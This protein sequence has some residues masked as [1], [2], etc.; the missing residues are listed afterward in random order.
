MWISWLF[1]H[2]AGTVQETVM[3]RL[4]LLTALLCLLVAAG[5]RAG[6][7]TIRYWYHI[8]NPDNNYVPGLVAKFEA[9]NPDIKVQAELIPWSSYYDNLHTSIIGG[10]AP[11]CGEVKLMAMP[12]LL[13]MEALEPL[14]NYIAAWDGR[15]DILDELWDK[16]VAADGKTYLLPLQYIVSYL[17]IRQD[18][19]DK[20]NVKIPTN[21]DEFLE[22][23]KALTLDTDG[24]G[25]IDIYGYGFR[26]GK[27]GQEHWGVFCMP[28]ARDLTT[29]Q[30]MDPHTVENNQFV[31]DMFRK[32]KV[33]PPSAPND[34]FIEIITAF[35]KGLTAMTIQH[36]G[37]AVMIER[38]L[39]DKATAVMVPA[40]GKNGE[41]WTNFGDEE[42]AIF[43]QSKNKDA[44][45]KWI[46]FLATGEYNRIWC[47]G[48]S[49]L[50]V[51]KSASRT[52][53]AHKQRFLDATLE[54][55]PFAYSL[56]LKPETQEF[57]NIVW[58]TETQRAMLGEIEPKRMLESFDKLFNK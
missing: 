15:D 28:N 49:Q 14:D 56:P 50:P 19:F 12:Q 41:R 22:A 27:A 13:E 8:D 38:D 48:A 47:E 58:P 44:A 43:A 1:R 21:R 57:V 39:G 4:A 26:G 5:A 11:D 20:Y 45:W 42:N 55:L 40:C 52:W 16:M 10:N 25:R 6:Q 53:T 17:Y 33:M 3:K 37:S 7:T 34:G 35:R 51:S 46:S 24:D 23:A 9:L 32:H 29:E 54:S 31:I 18:L 2:A 30:L 36:I